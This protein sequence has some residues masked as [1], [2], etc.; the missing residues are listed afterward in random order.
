VG[1]VSTLAQRRVRLDGEPDVFEERAWRARAHFAD[2]VARLDADDVDA[3]A[4]VCL[5]CSPRP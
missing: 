5:V 2:E 1:A 3:E 4:L